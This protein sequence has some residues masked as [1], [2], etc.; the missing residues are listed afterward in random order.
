M[1][2]PVSIVSAPRLSPP[3]QDFPAIDRR[4]EPLVLAQ[5]GRGIGL[6]RR[7]HDARSAAGAPTSGAA[8]DHVV[9]R[10]RHEGGQR[11]MNEEEQAN[12]CHAEEMH[13]ACGV[14]AAE[15]AR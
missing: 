9:E 4:D 15:T 14:V 3:A 8:R 12:A 1:S 7:A 5:H 13:L 2:Q 11:D 10:A 6:C